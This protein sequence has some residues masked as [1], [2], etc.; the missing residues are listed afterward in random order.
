MFGL[1][2][3]I[4][5]QMIFGLMAGKGEKSGGCQCLLHNIKT[6]SWS[7]SISLPMHSKKI[8]IAVIKRQQHNN[9]HEDWFNALDVVGKIATKLEQLLLINC[10]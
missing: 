6:D 4:Y 3:T 10:L 5:L 9:N 1:L 2:Q 8:F 7:N